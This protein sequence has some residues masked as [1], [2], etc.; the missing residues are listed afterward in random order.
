M[1]LVGRQITRQ[2]YNRLWVVFGVV[3][4][5]DLEA[6]LPF[7]PREGYYYFTNASVKRA[8]PADELTRKATAAGLRGESVPEGVA[9]ALRRAKANAQPDDMIYIGG[10][11]FIVADVPEL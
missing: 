4:D 5:K 3:E 6:E 9:E 1:A 8:M 7:L 2:K 11:T 10:S